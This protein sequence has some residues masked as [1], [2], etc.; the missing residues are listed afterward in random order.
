MLPVTEGIYNFQT[1]VK[2]EAKTVSTGAGVT[3]VDVVL[4]RPLYNNDYSTVDV[5]S[6]NT[7]DSPE[8][9]AYDTLTREITVT[10]LHATDSRK[11]TINYDI[12]ALNLPSAIYTV[13]GWVP[14]FWIL[15]LVCF[16]V[17]G[18]IVVVK[19]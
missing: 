8:V 1:D 11:F 13:L 10:G 16:A 4:A 15:I 6:D 2:V 7:L 14:V 9:T 17:I 3:S 19:K 12:Q 18:M 5:L